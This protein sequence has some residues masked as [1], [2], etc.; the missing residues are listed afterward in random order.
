MLYSSCEYYV[1]SIVIVYGYSV[2]VLLRYDYYMI[3]V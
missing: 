2:T 3:I 1:I